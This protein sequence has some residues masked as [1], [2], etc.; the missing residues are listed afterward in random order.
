MNAGGGVEDDL[1]EPT[2]QQ[3]PSGSSA[4][5][6]R[7]KASPETVELSLAAFDALTRQPIQ[8]ARFLFYR[9]DWPANFELYGTDG[10]MGTCT[11]RPYDDVHVH[12]ST[13]VTCC[14]E[15]KGPD[16]VTQQAIATPCLRP[17]WSCE[18]GSRSP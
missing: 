4:L 1:Y 8:G 13:T 16:S 15:P 12:G 18:P 9:R 11:L 17:T 10:G 5:V 2:E 14:C 7:R 6:F 3:V